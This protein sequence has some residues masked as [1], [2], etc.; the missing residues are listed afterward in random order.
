[1]AV[2]ILKMKKMLT[3]CKKLLKKDEKYVIIFSA[4]LC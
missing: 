3:F 2:G 1:M 4:V